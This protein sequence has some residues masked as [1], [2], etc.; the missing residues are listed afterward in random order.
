M[1]AGLT[2]EPRLDVGKPNV[3]RPLIGADCG[4]VAAAII[5]AI[6]Q[7]TAHAAS[8]HFPEG[9][10]LLAGE[11]WHGHDSADRARRK[12]TTAWAFSASAHKA[13][14]VPVDAFL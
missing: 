7:D 9:N 5:R 8:S 12:A 13:R 4:R 10:F 6:N 3:I 11:G 14:G 1:T 2:D